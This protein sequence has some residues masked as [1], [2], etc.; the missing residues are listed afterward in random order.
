[1]KKWTC[2]AELMNKGESLEDFVKR[3]AGV[4]IRLRIENNSCGRLVGY[5]GGRL[6]RSST[7]GGFPLRQAP[8][9]GVVF[10]QLLMQG[11]DWDWSS[12]NSYDLEVDVLDVSP[13]A[14]VEAESFRGTVA[15]GFPV[16]FQMSI[17]RGGLV[18]IEV[19]QEVDSVE[20]SLEKLDGAE[21]MKITVKRSAK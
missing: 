11:E 16:R 9:Y 20:Y 10:V 17:G 5:S 8:Q 12:P 2:A 21:V 15:P 1:M 7:C 6:V 19:D 13:P 14:P 3:Y 4:P 18:S